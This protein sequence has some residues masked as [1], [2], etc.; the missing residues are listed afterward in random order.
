MP[1]HLLVLQEYHPATGYTGDY[2]PVEVT[3]VLEGGQFGLSS[4]Y[5]V[6]SIKKTIQF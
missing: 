5:V 1:G 4:D 6:M 3:Y 2:E